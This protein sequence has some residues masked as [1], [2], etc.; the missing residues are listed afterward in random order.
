MAY[1]KFYEKKIKSRKSLKEC[2][3]F[4][5]T[6]EDLCKVNG[7]K[8]LYQYYLGEGKKVKLD[9]SYRELCGGQCS[10]N[11]HKTAEYVYIVISW[12]KDEIWPEEALDLCKQMHDE[13]MDVFPTLIAIHEDE[14]AVHAHMIVRKVD[15]YGEVIES[16]CREWLDFG[17]DY[18]GH[19]FENA[20]EVDMPYDFKSYFMLMEYL[21]F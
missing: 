11:K 1:I 19:Y 14:F 2:V 13:Y 10:W 4:N 6:D 15:G 7:E 21:M 20:D 16:S 8:L 12:D 3:E 17:D 18:Y 9:T 5:L